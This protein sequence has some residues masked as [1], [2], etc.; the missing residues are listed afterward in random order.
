MV[1]K[2][3]GCSDA[4]ATTP[5]QAQSHDPHVIGEWLDEIAVKKWQVDEEVEVLGT[6][7]EWVAARVIVEADSV[8]V[9][10]GDAGNRLQ[11]M[12]PDRWWGAFLWPADW[13]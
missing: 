8:M 10:L 11:K 13:E 12:I 5:I 1:P 4:R 7:G 3:H 9:T 6:S 2:G